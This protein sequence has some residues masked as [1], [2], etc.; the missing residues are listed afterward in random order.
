MTKFRKQVIDINEISSEQKNTILRFTNKK[1][2]FFFISWSN[3]KDSISFKI[4]KSLKFDSLIKI[5]NYIKFYLQTSILFS[6][7][8]S[9]QST[10]FIEKGC[11]H[12]IPETREQIRHFLILPFFHLSIGNYY[13]ATSNKVYTYF[14]NDFDNNDISSFR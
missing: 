8:R 10:C 14:Y 11:S 5:N 9:H 7:D 12:S 4:E 1:I 2:I 6:Y 3:R 13:F